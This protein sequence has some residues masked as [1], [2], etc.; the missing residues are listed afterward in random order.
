M[1]SILLSASQLRLE[2]TAKVL[3]EWETARPAFWAAPLVLGLV[4]KKSPDSVRDK[5]RPKDGDGTG[6]SV[7]NEVNTARYCAKQPHVRR[8]ENMVPAEKAKQSTHNAKKKS[9][10]QMGMRSVQVKMAKVCRRR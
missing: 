3:P 2:L 8:W 6:V 4:D 7:V 9:I 1:D 5:D 10:M